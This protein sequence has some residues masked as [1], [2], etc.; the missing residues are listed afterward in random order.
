LKA[1]ER[2]LQILIVSH[3][4][5]RGQRRAAPQRADWFLPTDPS[6]AQRGQHDSYI[7]MNSNDH[8]GLDTAEARKIA[9]WGWADP[10]ERIQA[11]LGLARDH[12]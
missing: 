10:G 11:T 4:R 9:V 2:S 7:L 3:D 5:R 6:A 8:G 1:L 12:L